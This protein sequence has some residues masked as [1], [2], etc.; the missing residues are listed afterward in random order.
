MKYVLTMHEHKEI[1]G[2]CCDKK[3]YIGSNEHDDWKL[4]LCSWT[5]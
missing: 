2:V 5:Q 1:E 4:A 3:S